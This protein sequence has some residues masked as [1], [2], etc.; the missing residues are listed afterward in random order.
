MA[1]VL[2]GG[3]IT[4]MRGS[5]AGT[6]FSKNRYGSYAR[7]RTVPVNPNSQRQQK[8][9]NIMGQIVSA[10]SQICT[11]AQREAWEVYAKAVNFTNALGQTITLT[12]YNHYI[13]SNM[14]RINDGFTRVDAAPVILLLPPT[15]G[16]FACEV[17]EA[18]QLVTVSFDDSAAWCSEDSAKMSIHQGVPK[19][20]AVAFYGNH[21]RVLGTLLGDS[22][23]PITSPQTIAVD[24]PVAANMKNWFFGR[25]QRDDSRL[26]ERFRDDCII[27]A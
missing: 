6:V 1:L 9:R 10:W 16:S 13:R 2:F 24:F 27:G 11:L 20:S 5:I 12:G 21:F 26:S 17:S 7:G 19:N 18:N 25:V 15:D 14:A 23:S 3:G 8:V 22:G 4:D